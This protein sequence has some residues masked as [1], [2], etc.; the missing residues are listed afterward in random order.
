MSEHP[1]DSSKNDFLLSLASEI[2]TAYVGRNTVS[3]D[4]LPAVI[5][6]V[7]KALGQVGNGKTSAETDQKPAVSIKKSYADD[8]I[9]C[10]EDGKKLKM[11]KRYLRTR[12]GMS[13]DEYREKWNLPSDYPMVAPNYAA[14][15]SAF[16]KK[17]G[18]GKRGKK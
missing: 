6:S 13:P 7:Y 15:R 10:L 14:K 4:E 2:V 12:Y 18:L 1:T 17:I 9:I 5:G 11:L 8:Y 16:A 3:V